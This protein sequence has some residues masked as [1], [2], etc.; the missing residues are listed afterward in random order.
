MPKNKSIVDYYRARAGEYEQIYYREVPDRRKEIDD[1]CTYVR[2]I[3][4]KKTVLDLACGTGYWTKVA[5]DSAS[6]VV[7][8]DIASEMIG[9]AKNKKYGCPVK[10]VV[11]D[12]YHLPFAP[13][14]FDLIILGFWLS[15]EPRQNYDNLFDSILDPLKPNGHIWMIDNNSPAEGAQSDS[16][17]LDEFGNNRKLRRLQ[18]GDEFIIV[19]NYFSK[20]ELQ[21]LL[22]K[23][24]KIADLIHQ[25]YYWSAL[26]QSQ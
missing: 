20:E 18:N 2:K 17:G 24:F 3:S 8:T 4:Q 6:C 23:R 16:V 26:L 1:A 21:N 25:K 15:H 14:S 5:S 9:E 7:A 19:K 10:F 13:K 12:L 11:S 22:S